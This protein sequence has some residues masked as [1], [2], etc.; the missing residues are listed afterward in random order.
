MTEYVVPP[1]ALYY[2][3]EA[4]IRDEF[5]NPGPSDRVIDIGARYGSYTLPALAAG[6]HVTAVDPH[7]QI[8]GLLRSAAELNGF[9]DR[10][11][12]ICAALL[13][14]QP[15]PEQLIAEIGE[16]WPAGHVEFTTLD[17]FA[18]KPDWIKVDVEGVELQVLQGGL[19]TLKRYHPRLLI[20]DHTR[21]YEWCRENRIADQVHDLLR[22]LGYHVESVPYSPGDHGGADRDFMIAT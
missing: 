10:L 11:N 18:W 19:E 6:A 9:G 2:D 14:D 12:T 22:G 15:Y 20:E 5:W 3:D 8:L 21:V 17:G 13:D 1:Y 7:A 4:E 16:R